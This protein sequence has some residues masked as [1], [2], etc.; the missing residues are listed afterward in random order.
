M[1]EARAARAQGAP[2]SRRCGPD[3]RSVAS[4]GDCR[5]RVG[6]LAGD[7]HRAGRRSRRDRRADRMAAHACAPIRRAPSSGGRPN[8]DRRVSRCGRP[9]RRRAPSDTP[10]PREH[11]AREERRNDQSF[12]C[13]PPL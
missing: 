12:H 10:R 2:G 5:C 7:R 13:R 6:R 9:R 1:N 4:T 3:G 8:S 11:R